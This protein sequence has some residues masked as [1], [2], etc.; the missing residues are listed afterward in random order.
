MDARLEPRVARAAISAALGSAALDARPEQLL[1][2][3][4]VA[5]GVGLLARWLPVDRLQQRGYERVGLPAQGQASWRL[6]A[7][8]SQLHSDCTRQLS[9]RSAARRNLAR[10]PQQRCE[11]LLGQW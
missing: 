7:G 9:D 8:G 6:H 3:G 1:Q 2:G 10:A 4:T 5:V 11:G